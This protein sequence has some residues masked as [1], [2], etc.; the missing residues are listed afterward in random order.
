MRSRAYSSLSRRRLVGVRKH[1]VMRR[2]L[3]LLAASASAANAQVTR[4]EPESIARIGV[5]SVLSEELQL[6]YDAPTVFG[7]LD[8]SDSAPQWRINEFVSDAA[9]SV[10]ARQ[11]MYDVGV[12][13][14]VEVSFRRSG[15]LASYDPIFTTAEQQ[16]YDTVAIVLPYARALPKY[17]EGGYGILV[18][19][20]S[21]F[22]EPGTQCAFSWLLIELWDVAARDRLE[23][24]HGLAC[25]R[26]ERIEIRDQLSDYS[27]AEQ[28][29][30]EAL[31][32]TSL[33]GSATIAIQKLRLIQ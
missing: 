6:R 29:L 30:I 27:P 32:K 25:H 11:R 8:N 12:I 24:E 1:D 28:S 20:N 16:G 3:I 18:R 9:A 2:A 15:R 26:D 13:E 33:R 21:P 23:S 22:G 17:Y 7:N 19:R 31:V 10:L 4:E 14:T 5:I